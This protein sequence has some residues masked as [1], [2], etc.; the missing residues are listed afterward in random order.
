MRVQD[1]HKTIIATTKHNE[2]CRNCAR[3]DFNKWCDA[4]YVLSPEKSPWLFDVWY[5]QYR[6]F[7]A[8]Y[9]FNNLK[10]TDL[11]YEH[12]WFMICG[13]KDIV[14]DFHRIPS[15]MFRTISDA[16]DWLTPSLSNVCDFCAYLDA[17]IIYIEVDCYDGKKD[18]Y[19]LRPMSRKGIA[20]FNEEPHRDILQDMQAEWFKEIQEYEIY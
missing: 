6:R 18:L 8:L 11:E 3:T 1:T 13:I 9:H 12:R 17:G 19:T 7:T 2:A 10:Y 4:H 20:A 16:L 5:K 15:Q 14:D